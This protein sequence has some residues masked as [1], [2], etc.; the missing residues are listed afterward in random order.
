MGVLG[1]QAELRELE[2]QVWEENGEF[3][4][5]HAGFEGSLGYLRQS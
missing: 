1:P 2:G 5:E 4:F 3:F